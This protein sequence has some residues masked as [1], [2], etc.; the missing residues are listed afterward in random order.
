M[1][2]AEAID[3]TMAICADEAEREALVELLAPITLSTPDRIR[4]VLTALWG[5]D[6]AADVT[7]AIDCYL[8]DRAR[9][10]AEI[11]ANEDEP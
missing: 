4:V 8:E 3:A 7:T 5:L 11:A 6:A 9:I 2:L 10:D 1:T